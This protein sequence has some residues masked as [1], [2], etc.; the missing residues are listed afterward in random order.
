MNRKLPDRRLI[1]KWRPVATTLQT[2]DAIP[3]PVALPRPL[4]GNR[5]DFEKATQYWRDT[6]T[7]GAFGDVLS[8][9]VYG[10][11][12]NEIVALGAEAQRTNSS[13]TPIQQL[14]I[15]DIAQHEEL[16]PEPFYGA[17]PPDSNIHPFQVPIRALRALLRSAP[18]N[19]LALLDYAQLQAAIGRTDR[20]ER[21]IR[22]SIA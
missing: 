15:R 4:V 11:F 20:A 10:D 7:A 22:T 9:S 5:E 2:T 12:V 14:L 1:P 6:K 19:A 16:L 21:A 13:V 8:F 17:V 18:T 3:L